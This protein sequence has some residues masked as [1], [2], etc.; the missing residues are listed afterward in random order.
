MKKKI[1]STTLI[2]IAG[3]IAVAIGGFAANWASDKQQMEEV[4]ESC[5]EYIS[6]KEES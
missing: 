1:D 4:R 3:W 2:K 5:Q 6:Q